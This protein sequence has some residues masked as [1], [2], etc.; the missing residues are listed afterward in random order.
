[1]IE[2]KE[3]NNIDNNTIDSKKSYRKTVAML[4]LGCAKVNQ[5][6]IPAIH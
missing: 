2:N 6:M 3:I 1:M 4:T 5:N